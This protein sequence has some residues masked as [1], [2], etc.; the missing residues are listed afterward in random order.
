MILYGSTLSPFVRKVVAFAAEK[1]IA[2]DLRPGGL[3]RGG[4]EFAAAS[5]FG[6]IPALRVPGA[7]DGKDFCL[8]DSTAIITY[9]EACSPSPDLIPAEPMARGRA[10]WFDEFADTIFFAVAVKIFANRVLRPKLLK[11]AFDES[12]ADAAEAD[13]L[14]P[15]FDY[16][17]RVIPPSGFLIEDRITLAD[18]A[19]C[20]PFANLGHG[21]VSVDGTRWPRTAAYVAAILA[22]PSFAPMIAKEQAFIAAAG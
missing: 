6:K 3:G 8:A 15:L 19:V 10:I 9:L 14:P 21:G 1:G 12:V 22:R 18:I 5:P 20:S 17:E 16:L 4:E 2:L 7:D 13:E 11:T